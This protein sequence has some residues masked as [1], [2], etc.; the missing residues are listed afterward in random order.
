MSDKRD[1]FVRL[2]ENR[3]NK[4]IKDIQ[5]IGNL[6][7]KSAYEYTDE[8]VKKIFRALQEAV[9]GS[10]KRYTEIGSQSRSE[11]KL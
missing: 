10:K 6:C 2:A 1:K 4:A 9:D 11:F 8:D 7:N 3:V 5:L